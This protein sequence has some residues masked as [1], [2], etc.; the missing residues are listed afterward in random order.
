MVDRGEYWPTHDKLTQMGRVQCDCDMT[1]IN[2]RPHHSTSYR[3]VYCYGAVGRSV[4]RSV[5]LTVY[6]DSDPCKND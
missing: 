4:R 5:C 1:A 3:L 6:Y 2:F